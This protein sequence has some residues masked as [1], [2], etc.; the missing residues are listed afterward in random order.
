MFYWKE[1]GKVKML[2]YD[3]NGWVVWWKWFSEGKFVK[4]ELEE[5]KIRDEL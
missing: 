4:G 1:Y 3:I 5:W 2:D